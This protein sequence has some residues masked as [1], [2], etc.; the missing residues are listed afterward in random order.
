MKR[1]LR[2]PLLHFL[3]LGLAIF[4]AFKVLGPVERDQPSIVVTQGMIDGQVAAFSRTWLRPPTPQE[5]DALVREYVREEVY[6]R[7]GMALGL[8]RDD[9][10]IRRRLQQK[11]EFIA[12]AAGMATEPTDDQLRAHLAAHPDAYRTD[13]RLSF[14]HVYLN[15]ERRGDTVAR[16]AEQLLAAIKV[17]GVEV[18]PAT[19]GD[20]T[21]LERV[22][23]NVALQDVAAQFGD[24]F[25]SHLAK[26]PVG[27]WLGPVDSAYGK[28]LVRI[29]NRTAGRVPQLDEARDAVR[30]DWANNQRV[31][32]NR[33]FYESLLK[34]YT[35]TIEGRDATALNETTGVAAR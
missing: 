26:M 32:A 2:E 7:E 5:I 13:E 31:A 6:Y 19:L 28:H 1:W 8:D 16:D 11:V 14:V 15:S 24:E 34:R 21:M 10:V 29:S 3:L 23:E 30:R 22:F 27:Q 25:A 20:A 12:E 33:K 18:D 9:T 17:G 35:V 4:A